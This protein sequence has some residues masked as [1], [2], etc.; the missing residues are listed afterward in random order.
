MEELDA[1]EAD[2]SV[3]SVLVVLAVMAVILL[4]YRWTRSV[5]VLFPPLLLA[6]VYAFAIASLPPLGVT[7]LNSNTAFLGSIIIGNGINVGLILLARYREERERGAS[8]DEA[9]VIGV[10]GARL[11]T[12]AAASAAAV[13]YASLVVTEFRGFRQFGC[14]GGVGMLASWATAFLLVPPLL[15]WLDDGKP[16]VAEA[17]PRQGLAARRL[18]RAARERDHRRRARG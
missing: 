12:L 16:I 9:I 14:I 7:E 2:L 10:W 15:K 5:L 6:T 8:V 1:L 13:S 11:G 17:A 18:H 3:S 4:Y